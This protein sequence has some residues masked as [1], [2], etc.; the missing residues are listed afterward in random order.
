MQC[1]VMCELRRSETGCRLV[2]GLEHLTAAAVEAWWTLLCVN[3]RDDRYCRCPAFT[4][5]SQRMSLMEWDILTRW[6][7]KQKKLNVLCCDGNR[8]SILI[9]TNNLI[10]IGTCPTMLSLE[11]HH[12]ILMSVSV[13]MW[14][15]Y[16]VQ[17]YALW[18]EWRHALANRQVCVSMRSPSY[19]I[20]MPNIVAIWD[21]VPFCHITG[22]ISSINLLSST[23]SSTKTFLKRNLFK[24]QEVRTKIGRNRWGEARSEIMKQV[25]IK[26][27][28]KV[29]K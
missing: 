24:S 27:K 5:W 3:F 10:K 11:V 25:S 12:P 6:D 17:F 29:S 9:L 7:G 2:T 21:S 28:G 19:S 16:S 14:P 1:I 4:I 22:L 26:K 20:K 18:S 13:T 15:I 8:L 23:C